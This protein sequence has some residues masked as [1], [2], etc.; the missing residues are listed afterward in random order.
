[1]LHRMPK[2]VRGDQ[3]EGARVTR[4]QMIA[5]FGNSDSSSIGSHLHCHVADANATLGA[6]GL[7]FVF[8]E[9]DLLGAFASIEAVRADGEWQRRREANRRTLEHPAANTVVRFR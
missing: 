1:M 3:E 8:R 6:E 5:G 9:C 2:R 7:P 4:G